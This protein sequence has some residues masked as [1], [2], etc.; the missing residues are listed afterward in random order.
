MICSKNHLLFP[1]PSVWFVK[2]S[3]TVL[4]HSFVPSNYFCTHLYSGAPKMEAVCLLETLEQIFTTCCENPQKPTIIWSRGFL[5]VNVLW[6]YKFLPSW[7]Y[8]SQM[9]PVN[10][11]IYSL[12]NREKWK[13][14]ITVYF[15]SVGNLISVDLNCN[16]RKDLSKYQYCS[17]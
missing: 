13:G 4:T 2:F 17:R 15:G 14:D 3:H 6:F 12:G 11:L 8:H 16:K 7:R 1:L 10:L 5:I 9:L